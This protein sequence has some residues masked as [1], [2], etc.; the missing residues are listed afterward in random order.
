MGRKD[1]VDYDYLLSRIIE[2]RNTNPGFDLNS[3]YCD[4]ELETLQGLFPMEAVYAL[5]QK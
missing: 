3:R 4:K 2:N 1:L 5:L